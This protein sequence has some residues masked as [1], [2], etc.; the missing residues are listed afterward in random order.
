M[1]GLCTSHFYLFFLIKYSKVKIYNK[2][3]GWEVLWKK[4]Y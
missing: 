3:K 2:I 4:G 1:T